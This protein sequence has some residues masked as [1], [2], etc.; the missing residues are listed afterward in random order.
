[1]RPVVGAYGPA[2]VVDDD[3]PLAFCTGY[4][5]PRVYV[6]RGALAQ[7]SAEELRAVLAHEAEHRRRRDPLRQ[8]CARVLCEALFFLPVLEALGD[9]SAALAELLA[10]DAAVEACA[11]DPAPL[12]AAMLLFG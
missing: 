7:T 1:A 2:L 4:L 9:R 12:A 11:G 6:S 3:R 8:A 5:S 10:D